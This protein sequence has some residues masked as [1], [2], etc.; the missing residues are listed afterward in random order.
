M[1]F[2]LALSDGIL[3]LTN[4][5]ELYH[6]NEFCIF[7]GMLRTWAYGSS[8]Q[9]T[10]A[11]AY[12]VYR[13]VVLQ[14]DEVEQKWY[15]L[16]CWG[17]PLILSCLP[18]I[19]SSF[20]YDGTICWVPGST[21]LPNLWRWLTIYVWVLIADLF[22]LFIYLQLF[23]FLRRADRGGASGKDILEKL[24]Y[25]PAVLLICTLP[26]TMDRFYPLVHG[27]RHAGL[28][29]ANRFALSCLGLGNALVYG[30]SKV[31]RREIMKDLC[32]TSS[33]Y[34]I[35]ELDSLTTQHEPMINSGYATTEEGE[36]SEND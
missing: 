36:Q 27:E 34:T 13:A 9:W 21:Q 29:T 16:Y 6:E 14:L 31:I 26:G 30:F 3:C 12:F 1:V 8:L 4:L 22:C 19:T 33:M 7:V 20:G 28:A 32:P 11:V 5:L 24:L 18:H 17:L 15:R 25:Y 23:L 2:C 10:M 35:S